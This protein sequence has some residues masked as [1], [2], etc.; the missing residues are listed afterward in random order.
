MKMAKKHIELT[1]YVIDFLAKKDIKEISRKQIKK[2]VRNHRAKIS[3]Y[4]IASAIRELV[5]NGILER[6]RNK[7]HVK[8]AK[9]ESCRKSI[10]TMKTQFDKMQEIKEK[11]SQYNIVSRAEIDTL[12]SEYPVV[13][14]DRIIMRLLKLGFISK[15]PR[16]QSRGKY[17]VT[18]QS[19]GKR[20]ITDPIRDTISLISRDVLF[21]YNSALELHGLS[22]YGMS[23]VVYFHFD[24]PRD[25]LAVG[26]FTL[27]SVKL[28]APEIGKMNMEIGSEEIF[29]TDVERTIIDC[30]HYPKYAVGWE[31]VLYALNRI[32]EIDE[33][34]VLDYLEHINIPS[35]F[36]KLGVV[37][38]H[39]Q[40]RWKISQNFLNTLRM[41]CPPSPTRFFRNEPGKLNKFWNV[42]LPPG[43]FES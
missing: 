29:L 31:N 23:F 4:A 2:R 39:N 21:C 3:D 38:E 16:K 1:K 5:R 26:D 40:E 10:G 19:N 24:A 18:K 12:L 42:F 7:Y 30:V 28:R 9:I 37:L 41:F 34:R 14:I 35:L 6:I 17:V 33:Q 20:I 25:R 11:L 13:L 43:I 27:K 22:R 8:Q 15:F 36:S 32:D